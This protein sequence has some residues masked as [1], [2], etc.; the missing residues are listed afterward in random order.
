M[1][2]P[3][4]RWEVPGLLGLIPGDFDGN[5]E[6][7]AIATTSH[8][9]CPELVD[10]LLCNS[11]GGGL[12]FGCSADPASALLPYSASGQPLAIDFDADTKADL[13]AAYTPFCDN[14]TVP[15]GGTCT[16]NGTL[17]CECTLVCSFEES[18][19]KG[20]GGWLFGGGG[21]EPSKASSS[22][23]SSA[24]A[25]RS[26]KKGAAPPNA[27]HANGFFSTQFTDVLQSGDSAELFETHPELARSR[28]MLIIW[29]N[30]PEAEGER[31][32]PVV[33]DVDCLRSYLAAGGTTVAYVGERAAAPRRGPRERGLIWS[34]GSRRWVIASSV[35]WPRLSL[36]EACN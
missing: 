11:S 27:D 25:S 14:C 3:K 1:L 20:G 5:G 8:P 18:S 15:L 2:G 29:P 4:Q 36:S 13:L 17:R 16:A 28:S 10:L 22:S 26:G 23:S 19:G 35:E 7:D 9:G 34:S 30:N 33:W 21:K 6:L 12:P 31:G 24:A 32:Q